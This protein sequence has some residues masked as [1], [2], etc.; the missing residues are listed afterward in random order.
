MNTYVLPDLSAQDLGVKL[1]PHG[2]NAAI[3][4]AADLLLTSAISG[5]G[6]MDYITGSPFV[7]RSTVKSRRFD[8]VGAIEK[9]KTPRLGN[10]LILEALMKYTTGVL[11]N[12]EGKSDGCV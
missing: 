5:V 6:L 11:F 1:I 3:G 4:L 12:I 10:Q 7:N 8:E 2:W 9:P